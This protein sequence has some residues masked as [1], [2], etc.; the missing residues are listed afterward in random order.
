MFSFLSPS[1]LIAGLAALIPL[2]IHLFSRRRVK[3]VEF[4]S[5]KHLQ[6]MKRQQV[7]RLKIRQI[8]LLLLRM[9]I[10]LAIV[11]AF[12]RPATQ[13]GSIGTHASVS[14]VILFDNSASMNREVRDGNLFELSRK[15]ANQLLDSFADKDEVAL[16]AMGGSSSYEALSGFGS[17][18]TAREW[19]ERVTPGHGR[20]NLQAALVEAAD[21][22]NTADNL[23]RELYLLSDRQRCSLPDST[24]LDDC[25]ARVYLVD[26][27]LE[28]DDNC[29][30]VDVDLGSHL[31][32]PG[33][34]FDITVTIKNYSPRDRSDIIASLFMDGH[35]VTQVD[36][37]TVAN[38]ETVV[39][40]TRTVSRGGFHSGYVELSDDKYAA[41]NRRFFSFHIP[42]QFNILLIGQ[43]EVA[44]LTSLALAPSPALNQHWSVKTV[45]PDNLGGTDLADYDVIFVTSPTGL[46][47]TFVERTRSFVRRGKSMLVACGSVADTGL[48]NKSWS[49]PTGLV[50]DKAAASQVTR[51]GYYSLA[52]VDI[53]HP[54]FSIFGFESNKI[55]ELKFYT[56]PQVHSTDDATTLARFS[57]N[58]P[59]LV[60]NS[61]GSGRVLT[62]TGPLSPRYSDL[63]G[64]A[65]FVPF[66]S[67]IAEY[68]ASDLSSYDR[69]LFV[70]D[71][72][73]RSIALGM[74]ASSSLEM[75]TPDNLLYYLTPEEDQASLILRVQPT[76]QPGINQVRYLGREVDRF[77]V[78]IDPLEGDLSATDPESFATAIGAQKYCLLEQ[79]QTL[80][81]AIGEFRFGKELWP[82]FLWLAIMLLISEMLLA[83][84]TPPEDES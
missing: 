48:F 53:N 78:N 49:E 61:Y 44:Q 17:M 63:T 43:G 19:L 31:L 56:V 57:G 15:R 13:S 2:I 71:N 18:A 9:L 39:R 10:L 23:N 20:A 34:D 80:S 32:L 21:L 54:V 8:L 45:A 11:L 35:R 14:A 67:R 72:I 81:A 26:I 36:V 41:D 24:I 58:H 29:G 82:L 46:S 33:H 42:R 12:A 52:S 79:D 55:P 75:I 68:L 62:F 4:S 3:V 70:G 28:E 1:I 51:A 60:E 77:A 27:P 66:L 25:Q 74:S 40:F 50:F 5:L 22:L 65:M 47:P 30:I 76:D 69:D 16:I 83:R 59:A 6:A 37:K 73:V 84:G 64:H 38:Q 7:R